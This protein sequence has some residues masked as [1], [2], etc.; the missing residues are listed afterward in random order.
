MGDQKRRLDIHDMKIEALKDSHEKILK[1]Q[2]EQAVLLAVLIKK[3][4]ITNDEIK[5]EATRL[6][7]ELKRREDDLKQGKI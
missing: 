2:K 7:A 4:G 1:I 3:G 6:D 5:E